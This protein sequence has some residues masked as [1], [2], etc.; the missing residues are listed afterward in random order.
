MFAAATVAL[1]FAAMA[2]QISTML[3]LL[4]LSPEG[5]LGMPSLMFAR[6]ACLGPLASPCYGNGCAAGVR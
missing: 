2:S 1:Q 3:F 5:S 4:K 6:R